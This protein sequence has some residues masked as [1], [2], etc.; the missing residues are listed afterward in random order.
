MGKGSGSVTSF[1]GADGF[2]TIDRRIERVD[3]GELVEVQRLGREVRVP[4]LV[5]VGSHC[6]GLDWLLSQLSRRGIAVKYMA[7]GSN[8]GLESAKRGECD[9]AGIHLMD[10][11]SGEYNAP[12][13]TNELELL[14]GYTRRQGVVFR[15]GDA[16][17][18]G[19]SAEQII[20]TA[21]NDPACLMMNRNAGSGTRVL[22]DQLLEGAS[23]AGYQLQARSHQAVAAAVAQ[24][25]A[26]WGVAIET[27]AAKENLEFVFCQ[28]E[29]F[30][31]VAP[32]DRRQR[33][34]VKRFAELL[35]EP[36]TREHLLTLGLT[37]SKRG[38]S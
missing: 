5:V 12:F 20:A 23:P 26:D 37:Q 14:P 4:D 11:D 8:A 38:A 29:Q 15:R 2:V 10:A 34:A 9:L 28:N 21:N 1:S 6:L 32:K 18:E 17:F 33:S 7:V 36:E 27:A 13:L 25:R 30:D 35:Q 22:I 19:K 24:G 3:A 16:R 31:F